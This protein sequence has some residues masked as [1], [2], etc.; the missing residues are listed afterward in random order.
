MLPESAV[1]EIQREAVVLR[2][3]PERSVCSSQLVTKQPAKHLPAVRC[4]PRYHQALDTVRKKS[5]GQEPMGVGEQRRLTERCRCCSANADTQK[6]QLRQH[7][8][9]TAISLKCSLIPAV[10]HPRIWSSRH[11][12]DGPDT[13]NVDVDRVLGQRVGHDCALLPPHVRQHASAGSQK[14]FHRFTAT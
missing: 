12:G 3:C 4:R 13:W 14:V 10:D 5:E 7:S 9:P 11:E 2:H 1:P 8:L 6:S